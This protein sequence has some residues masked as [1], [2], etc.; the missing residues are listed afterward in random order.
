MT[1]AP[2]LTR[3]ITTTEVLTLK[4]LATEFRPTVDGT[5]TDASWEMPRSGWMV[6]TQVPL[7]DIEKLSY[8]DLQNK[9]APSIFWANEDGTYGLYPRPS[10]DMKIMIDV[11]REVEIPVAPEFNQ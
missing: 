7:K 4:S 6:I 11:K 5:V 10:R 8:A 3:T 1:D 2:K 9:G